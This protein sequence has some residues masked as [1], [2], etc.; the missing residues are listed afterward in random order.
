MNDSA[1]ALP[2]FSTVTVVL[3]TNFSEPNLAVPRL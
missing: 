3:V 1:C 2:S